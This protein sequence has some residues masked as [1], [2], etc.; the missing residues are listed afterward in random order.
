MGFATPCNRRIRPDRFCAEATG[1]IRAIRPD[2][3]IDLGLDLPGYGRVAPLTARVLEAL[4]TAGGRLPVGDHSLPA[5]IRAKFGS[6]KKAFKQ[7]LG[8]LLRQRMICIIADGIEL[9]KPPRR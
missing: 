3:K 6:S 2:G 9:A 5:E 4:K 8:S 1:F 7:A